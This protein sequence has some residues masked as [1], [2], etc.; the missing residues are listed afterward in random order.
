MNAGD[1]MEASSNASEAR[2]RTAGLRKHSGIIKPDA[3]KKKKEEVD[4]INKMCILGFRTVFKKKDKRLRLCIQ[5]FQF[6][7]LLR[8]VTNA[9]PDNRHDLF[10]PVISS[11]MV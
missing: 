9:S 1:S 8:F 2:Q 11:G 10:L 6:Q 5:F 4:A 3:L 7:V